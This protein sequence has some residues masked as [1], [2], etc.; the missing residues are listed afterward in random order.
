MRA[1]LSLNSEIA[2]ANADESSS[3]TPTLFSFNLNCSDYLKSLGKPTTACANYH[4]LDLTRDRNCARGGGSDK[5]G[6]DDVRMLIDDIDFNKQPPPQLPPRSSQLSM[7]SDEIKSANCGL[8]FKASESSNSMMAKS[9][10]EGKFK[11]ITIDD[12]MESSLNDTNE[13]FRNKITKTNQLSHKISPSKRRSPIKRQ[14]P[15][16][17]HSPLK[18]QP[19]ISVKLVQSKSDLIGSTASKKNLKR[20]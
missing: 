11:K 1:R 7:L 3:S 20:L 4:S 5:D 16:K 18:K 13:I 9:Q 10:L 8:L 6:D 17:R 15:F 14:S 19:M 12:N 2:A